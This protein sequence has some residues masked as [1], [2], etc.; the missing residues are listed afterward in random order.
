MTTRE[1]VQPLR[2]AVD[3]A[4]EQAASTVLAGAAILWFLSAAFDEVTLRTAYPELVAAFD[5]FIAASCVGLRAFLPRRPVSG[6]RA[7]ALWLA[8]SIFMASD[9]LVT[10][11]LTR[12]ATV[13]R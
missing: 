9:V 11:S 3:E 8:L 4:H 1:A 13:C 5:V 12:Q 2:Q 6:A 10:M 7:D